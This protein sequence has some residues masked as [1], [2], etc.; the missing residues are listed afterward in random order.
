VRGIIVGAGRGARLIP[1]TNEGP[2]CLMDGLGGRRLLDWIL[3]ALRQGGVDDIVFVGGYR[4]EMVQA[5]YPELRYYRN[6]RWRDNNILGSLMYA[7][8]ELDTDVILSYADIFYGEGIVRRLQEASGDL[9]LAV[10]FEWLQ[11][12]EGRVG[13]SVSE[14]ENVVVE[15]DR[16]R[17]VGKHLSG[18]TAE[19]EFIGLTYLSA[20]AA[21]AMRDRYFELEADQPAP[22]QQAEILDKAYVTDMLQELIDRGF[23]AGSVALEEPWFELDTPYDLDHA[24]SFLRSLKSGSHP[25]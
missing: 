18:D 15:G 4:M 13:H 16:V 14:A 22:F 1:A 3:Q 23:N 20:V 17:R 8:A 9:A 12:Y 19:G 24:R 25:G 21:R 7:A 11:Q 5:L 6:D 2:K 10:D